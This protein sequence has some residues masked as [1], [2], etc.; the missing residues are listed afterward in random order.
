MPWVRVEAHALRHPKLVAVGAPGM[1]L[2]LRALGY[3]A[4]HKTDGFLPAKVIPSL[5]DDFAD[6]GLFWPRDGRG[7]S[8]RNGVTD[9]VTALH[10]DD[11]DRPPVMS[12]NA[13]DK[14]RRRL[15]A[16]MVAVGL[17][18]K[19][20][21]GYGIHDY[22]DYQP[23]ADDL[24]A[25]KTRQREQTRQ[26]V[27]RHRAKAKGQP[28][29]APRPNGNAVTHTTKRSN[30]FDVTSNG[31]TVDDPNGHHPPPLLTAVDLVQID[32]PSK[33]AQEIVDR[34]RDARRM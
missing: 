30:V 26:R 6:I 7:L 22:L 23:A 34:L 18:D 10:A 3:A 20:P 1:I 2:Y 19:K 8:G 29:A 21:D 15:V 13:F 31:V 12:P 17:W 28:M 16:Q 33:K 4:E 32:D 24:K 27:R 25:A 5:V 11:D 9:S 14:R